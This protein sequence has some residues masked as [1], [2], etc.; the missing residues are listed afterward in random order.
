MRV[1]VT[2]ATGYIGRPLVKRLLTE[3]HEVFALA[4]DTNKADDLC[5]QG[6]ILI[7]GDVLSVDAVAPANIDAVIHLAF[8]LFPESN[9]RTN[10]DGSLHV[11]NMALRRKVRRFIYNS[12]ALV[13][14]PTDPSHI[15]TELDVCRPNM[16]FARQ[17]LIIE[18][19]L[20]KLA[21]TE[22]FPAV[23]LRPS[24]VYGGKGGYFQK[25]VEML[26]QGRLPICGDGSQGIA[27]TEIDDLH[28]A[29]LRCLEVDLRP[30]ET[31]NIGT[32]AII[33]VALIFDRI[34]SA[35]GAPRPRRIPKTISLAAGMLM[36]AIYGLVGRTP[37]FN[38]EI[39][40][41]ACMRAGPRSIARA[42]ALIG[43]QPRHPDPL[44]AIEQQYLSVKGKPRG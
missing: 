33:P 31:M 17:Q 43:F 27:F 32:P 9:R 40:K 7:K 24:E 39:A 11:I 10:V 12:S 34:A 16:R 26:H 23:I 20:R 6:A 14:G 38:L 21:S 15:V 29:I 42:Q 4:R 1:F 41:V 36:G 5:N 44:A 2:G 37:S 18:N 3:G 8:S 35:F 13:Y 28:D 25:M 30:G 22:G 19:A